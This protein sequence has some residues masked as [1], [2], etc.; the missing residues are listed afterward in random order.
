M[1]EKMWRDWPNPP[2]YHY[3]YYY[4]Y[5]Y[6]CYYHVRDVSQVCSFVA[7]LG[8]PSSLLFHNNRITGKDLL[9]L[10]PAHLQENLGLSEQDCDVL[11][12]GLITIIE[13]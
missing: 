13:T 6:L 5:H 3:Y 1:N 4:H 9:V 11:R 8:L 2:F 10:S 12:Q 7:S